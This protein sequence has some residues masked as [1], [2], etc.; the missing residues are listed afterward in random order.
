MSEPTDRDREIRVGQIWREVDPRFVRFARVVDFHTAG[1]RAIQ[2]RTVSK[3]GEDWV[4]T[5][6]SRPSWCN[7]ERF[8]GK[9]GGYKLYED[10]L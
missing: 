1:R 4:P 9:R 5:P 7:R 3:I 2:I 6:H 10:A 8:N